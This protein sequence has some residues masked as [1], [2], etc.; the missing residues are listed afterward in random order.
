MTLSD[1][2]LKEL[3]GHIG[4][5]IA[6][7]PG[8]YTDDD[9]GVF[10]I[11]H[12]LES[13]FLK[14]LIRHD[15]F[16]PWRT[17]CFQWF[18]QLVRKYNKVLPLT[19]RGVFDDIMND[20]KARTNSGKTRLLIRH[21]LKRKCLHTPVQYHVENQDYD[22][23]TLRVNYNPNASVL[24]HEI[25][26]QIFL[27]LVL[28][29]S[30]YDFNFD[31]TNSSFLDESWQI[32]KLFKTEL[33]PCDKLGLTLGFPMGFAVI[34]KIL[35][36]SVAAEFSGKIEVGD[37]MD[38]FNGTPVRHFY[39]SKIEGL[40]RKCKK[41][42]FKITFIKSKDSETGQIFLP[43]IKL[44]RVL[45]MDP[46]LLNYPEPAYRR[47]ATKSLE[48]TEFDMGSTNSE[49][50]IDNESILDRLQER[51][52]NAK[53]SK[54]KP[55]VQEQLINVEVEVE[56]QSEQTDSENAVVNSNYLDLLSSLVDT[57]SSN[58][59]LL[60][61]DAPLIPDL[62]SEDLPAQLILESDE[63]G[64]SNSRRKEDEGIGEQSRESYYDNS[65]KP[66]QYY[67][68]T[69]PFLV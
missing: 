58:L 59:D 47:R 5:L 2:L 9:E 66:C 6:S 42:P 41:K 62:M 21:C 36:H 57:T 40:F 48:N 50:D 34:V 33:V 20:R 29:L 25:L 35:D 60:T 32:P 49:S 53:S 46:E 7:R 61:S 4:G 22:D 55:E 14:G 54:R 12:A 52:T 16:T 8:P 18:H 28:Q 63:N 27:S 68:D 67:D 19:F 31:L 65:T 10:L 3:K 69:H 45:G 38:E 51:D 15:G 23:S 17:D 24:G 1:P 64:E 56:K 39:G 11:C 37:I 30:N 44:Y 43:A 13:I 26:S